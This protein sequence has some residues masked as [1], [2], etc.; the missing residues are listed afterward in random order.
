[1]NTTALTRIFLGGL[2][3]AASACTNGK[4]PDTTGDTDEST[5][6]TSIRDVPFTIETMTLAGS[7]YVNADGDITPVNI[8]GE[9]LN[10]N[11][12]FSLGGPNADWNNFDPNSSDFCSLTLEW[13]GTLERAA[14][15]DDEGLWW[16]VDLPIATAQISNDCTEAD[17]A[18]IQGVQGFLAASDLGL[19]VGPRNSSSLIDAVDGGQFGTVSGSVAGGYFRQTILTGQLVP[20]VQYALAWRF[21]EANAPVIE[22][23]APS[24]YPF[25]DIYMAPM[26]DTAQ[27]DTDIDTDVDTDTDAEPVDTDTTEDVGQLAHGLYTIG[28]FSIYTLQ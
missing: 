7:F 8:Q 2:L 13:P 27:P 16:G 10:T 3:I 24:Y 12:T 23:N 26:V 4:D 14:W 28:T 15:T 18:D 1:M 6:D 21:D 20:E 11:V 22:N 17:P 5:A 9:T 19:G 25:E